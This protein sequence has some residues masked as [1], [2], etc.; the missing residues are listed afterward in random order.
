MGCQASSQELLDADN[1]IHYSAEIEV[2]NALYK[3]GYETTIHMCI[4]HEYAAQKYESKLT[5]RA[6]MWDA[7][8]ARYA[9]V[10]NVQQNHHY[11]R[12]SCYLD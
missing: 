4:Y 5:C 12:W 2:Y 9:D 3:M 8:T 10:R 1:Q 7:T 11:V 6:A